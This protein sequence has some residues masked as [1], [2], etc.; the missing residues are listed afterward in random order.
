MRQGWQKG[1]TRRASA[2]KRLVRAALAILFVAQLAG[3]ALVHVKQDNP[4]TYDENRRGDV[5]TTGALSFAT[6][7]A[8]SRLGLD[9]DD[10][11]DVAM[12]CIRALRQ[13]TLLDTDARLSALAELALGEA[14]NADKTTSDTDAR[15]V[16]AY[17]D[18][19]RYAYAY[20]FFGDRSP[21]GARSRIARPRCATATTTPS[22]GLP[23]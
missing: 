15:R 4:R 10:C 13:A 19:A 2:F 16:S 18:A 17:L 20:L 11:V 3:C 9:P 23:R 22:S 12:P 14:L 7:N 6:R 8:I 21:R 5:L 1:A